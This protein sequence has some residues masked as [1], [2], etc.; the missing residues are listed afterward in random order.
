LPFRI[1]SRLISV[2]LLG[3][4][5]ACH[6]AT[7]PLAACSEEVSIVVSQGTVPTIE[8]TPACGAERLLVSQPFTAS[9]GVTPQWWI[10]ASDRLIA[11]PLRYGRTP[12][13]MTVEE[14]PR[15]LSSGNDY[16]VVLV[17]GQILVGRT[18]FTP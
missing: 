3:M 12:R 7:E 8:W 14:P 6:G 16:I 4:G 10:R 15:Q 13:G 2:P 5:L 11:P 17:A 1:G 9:A 18:L